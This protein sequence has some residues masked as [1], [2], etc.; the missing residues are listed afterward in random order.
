MNIF[1]IHFEHLRNEA[2]YQFLL[3]TRQLIDGDDSV[4]SI[5]NELL[6]GFYSLIDLEGR[7]VDAIKS[8]A[9][10]QE[11]VD[12]DHRVDR[13][14]VAINAAVES[15]FHHFDATIVDAAR[16]LR[17]RLKSFHGDID[18]KSY[19]EES[20]A[21]KILVADLHSSYFAYV[22][23]IGINS[24]VD[25][26]AAAQ[27][28]FE[29]LYLARN[30]ERS[31]RPQDDLK[32]VRREVEVP[33]RTIIERIDAY[34][35]VN[36]GGSYDSFIG[37]L[38]ESITYFNEHAHQH[39]K[40]DLSTGDH[41]VI[42]PIE[43]QLHTGKPITVVPKVYYRA[44]GQSTAELYLGEDF[45]VTYKNN[46]NPGMAELTIHGKGKYKGQRSTTFNIAR[47]I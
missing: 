36:G 18:K 41:T 16:H 27:N 34:A 30:A 11:M 8:S 14:L 19:E 21:V 39:T 6:P 42:E 46:K 29:Q 32:K 12:A 3:I 17:L 28:D 35:V 4:R 22:S 33:Y 47:A 1:K 25:A 38:N 13:M 5:V 40:I 23:T 37:K 7:L 2:H 26:L 44:D 24:L 45:S 43:T 10:T 15:A 9:Y 31:E 20:A